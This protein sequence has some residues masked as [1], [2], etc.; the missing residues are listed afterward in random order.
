MQKRGNSEDEARSF[1]EDIIGGIPEN[2]NS[3][4]C[5]D[6]NARIGELSP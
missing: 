3:V 2:R 6:W 4:I 1:I 5:G